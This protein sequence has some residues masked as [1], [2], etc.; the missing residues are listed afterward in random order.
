MAMCTKVGSQPVKKQK[1]FGSEPMGQG[2][3]VQHRHCTASTGMP[4]IFLTWA[5]TSTDVGA[6]EDC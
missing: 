5:E 6:M 2:L 1:C 3:T 4:S